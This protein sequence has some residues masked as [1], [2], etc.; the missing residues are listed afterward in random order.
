MILDKNI[1]PSLYE[2]YKVPGLTFK[3]TAGDKE[4]RFHSDHK[5]SGHSKPRL[6]RFALF[7]TTLRN[8][9]YSKEQYEK[10]KNS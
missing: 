1:S 5:N 3:R 8:K 9:I 7:Y 4:N 10:V 6:F 2:P